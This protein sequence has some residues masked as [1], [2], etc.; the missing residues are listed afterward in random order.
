MNNTLNHKINRSGANP[1]TESARELHQMLG[2][3]RDFT[4]WIKY[5][6]EAQSLTQGKDF[7]PTLMKSTGGRPG[8]DYLLTK[9]AAYKISAQSRVNSE[10]ASMVRDNFAAKAMTLDKV[11]ASPEAGIMVLTQ[12]SEE[13]RLRE[14]AEAKAKER[15]ALMKS[16]SLYSLKEAADHIAAPGYGRNNLCQLLRERRVFSYRNRPYRQYIEAGY[17]KRVSKP[18]VDRYGKVRSSITTVV[19]AKGLSYLHKLI[20]DSQYI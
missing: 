17:F 6:L 10:P 7:S 19:T 18:F 11:F 20:K 2:V 8:T 15:D 9:A 16:E 14:A 4:S 13:K 1:F 3:G 12:L 5:Q